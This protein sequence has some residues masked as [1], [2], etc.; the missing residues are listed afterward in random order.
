MKSP[1]SLYDLRPTD[2]FHSAPVCRLDYEALIEYSAYHRAIPP[3]RDQRL[4][5]TDLFA[6]L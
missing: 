3:F 2:L 6:T 4:V 1:L 5:A